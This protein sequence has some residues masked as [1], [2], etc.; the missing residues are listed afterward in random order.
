[1]EIWCSRFRPGWQRPFFSP[2]W[3]ITLPVPACQVG[4]LSCTNPQGN[5]IPSTD[6]EIITGWHV[7]AVTM[8]G[9]KKLTCLQCWE[10]HQI[11]AAVNM[12]QAKGTWTNLGASQDYKCQRLPK[13]R[14]VQGVWLVWN[15]NCSPVGFLMPPGACAEW[16]VLFA[17]R[18]LYL[19]FSKSWPQLCL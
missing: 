16:L 6:L 1:M 19:K 13:V 11:S 17:L 9:I 10:A 15:A 8:P 5:P 4:F 7:R 12:K 3:S 18:T 14:P 2:H